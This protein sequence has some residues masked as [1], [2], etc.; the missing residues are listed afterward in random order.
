MRTVGAVKRPLQPWT[1]LVAA[2]AIATGVL[3]CS[4]AATADSFQGTD[5]A[6]VREDSGLSGAV[7]RAVHNASMANNVRSGVI[8]A[9]VLQQTG[10][11]RN[12]TY[13]RYGALVP[14]GLEAWPET[15]GVLAGIDAVLKA[16]KAAVATSAAARWNVKAGDSLVIVGWNGSTM[17]VPIGAIVEDAKLQ[18]AEIVVW[19]RYAARAK[20]LYPDRVVMWGAR[21]AIEKALVAAK[22]PLG[23]K[24]DVRSANVR[25][26]A[27]WGLKDP[28]TPEKISEIKARAGEFR[29]TQRGR[30]LIHIDD[31]W[32]A[33]LEAVSAG[34]VSTKC[35]RGLGKEVQAAFAGMQV[36]GLMPVLDVKATQ[37]SGGCQVSRE[38]AADYYLR[39]ARVHV[40]AWG[41]AYEV[42]LKLVGKGCDVVRAWRSAGWAWVGQGSRSL[43]FQFT[44]RPA[45]TFPSPRCA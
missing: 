13:E 5:V 27:S 15:Y 3:V 26:E 42:R 31:A 20:W 7:V 41:T 19:D 37:R 21:G 32:L 25:V 11:S 30:H 18:N 34:G 17:D 29:Y 35:A 22:M 9:L 16:Q 24:P 1:H 2:L 44:G 33:T 4:D 8:H 39:T 10:V 12:G 14:V 23:V 43:V 38:V 45:G 36:A 40:R 6:V 28:N